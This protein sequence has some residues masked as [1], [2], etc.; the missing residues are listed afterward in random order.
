MSKVSVYVEVRVDG[1]AI[2]KNPLINTATGLPKDWYL[3]VGRIKRIKHALLPKS[4][5]PFA[6]LDFDYYL[7]ELPVEAQ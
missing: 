6:S 2:H 5:T 3:Q 7:Y 4:K 1:S